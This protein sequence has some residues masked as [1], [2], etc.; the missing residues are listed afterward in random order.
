MGLYIIGHSNQCDE[1]GC[2][3]LTTVLPWYVNID[4][5]FVNIVFSP[6]PLGVCIYGIYE[7]A[8]IANGTAINISTQNARVIRVFFLKLSITDLWLN[9][10]VSPF[11]F[12]LLVA[13]SSSSPYSYPWIIIGIGRLNF[14]LL[15]SSFQFRSVGLRVIGLQ[16]GFY[17]GIAGVL[18]FL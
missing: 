16:H 13:S 6:S 18:F 5:A 14:F 4:S 3:E 9:P 7:S 15:N 10:S 17:H 1:Y 2:V 8:Y 12:A 11:G